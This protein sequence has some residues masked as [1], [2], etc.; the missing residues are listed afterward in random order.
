MD[1]PRCHEVLSDKARFC[2]SCGLSFAS[3]DTPTEHVKGVAETVH[4]PDALIG[5]V[6]DGKYKLVARLGEGGMGAVY[7]ASR[8]LIGDEVA[9]KVLLQKYVAESAA[10]ERFRREAR[11]A[12]M[13]RH[14]NVVAIYDFGEAKG[15]DLP[16]YIVMEL[17]E[18]V[19]LRN[20]L[21]QERKLAPERAIALMRQI[22]A[23]VGAAH[24]R[25]IWHRDLKPD[26]IIVVPPT[27]DDESEIVKV[28]DF[29]IAK[30]R[31]MVGGF[32]LTQTGMVMGTPYYM[33]PEQCRGESL[34]ARSDVYSLGAM[35]YEML[36]GQ[37][38]FT[39]RTSTGV[40]A[41]HLTEQPEPLANELKVPHA[42]EAVIM[43]SLAKDPDARQMDAAV[44]SKELQAANKAPAAALSTTQTTVEAK[45]Q[46]PPTIQS[47]Q[48]TQDAARAD[49][50]KSQPQQFDTAPEFN[51]TTDP[52]S[53]S[54]L[55]LAP[56]ATEAAKPRG[57]GK[58][59]MLIGALVIVAGVIAAAMLGLFSS[60]KE[61]P[62]SAS[63]Q[64]A[65]KSSNGSDSAKPASRL[66]S[67]LDTPRDLYEVALSANG[68]L[69]ASTG[70][71][72]RVRLWNAADGR[73]LKEL[74]GYTKSGRCVAVSPDG[75]TVASGND[76]GAIRLWHASD[77]TLMNTLQGHTKFVFIVNFSPD[78]QTLISAG[79]DKTVRVWRVSDGKQLATITPSDPNDLIITISPD[80]KTIALLGAD[81]GV[82]LM[83]VDDARQLRTLVDHHYEVTAG[84]FSRDGQTLALGSKDGAVRLWRVMDGTL[85]R[86]LEG[87]HGEI[88]SVIFSPD[89]QT[90]VAGWSDGNI[91]L[92]RVSDGLELKTLEGHKK[93]V[94]SLAFSDN[95]RVLASGSDDKTI[96]LWQISEE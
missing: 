18:G 21:N 66:A 58:V 54:K 13:L 20:L 29:G 14:P 17:V 19:S 36:N 77:G 82:K 83:S 70:D 51:S 8:V 45:S 86:T 52:I 91:R 76:D 33:S 15:E 60:K 39:A 31:D 37:P 43:K 23:G 85:I 89:N 26:N 68:Q 56:S 53:L 62:T 49:I 50:P 59:W 9:V 93:N 65:T 25:G 35:L 1:C 6:L 64:A 95:G 27:D 69:V 12:A 74:T 7:R 24:R 32:T 38:P 41:K 10:I 92:W 28:V 78:G 88:G 81:R 3:F 90:V 96:R 2:S 61:T 40:V 75:E 94:N 73:A 46:P 57:G 80:L 47:T 11:A 55:G 34:D 30:L 44:F 79:A 84:A 63:T 48:P 67:V 87:T 42:L 22:C 71:E 72:N 5:H 16:A 4:A